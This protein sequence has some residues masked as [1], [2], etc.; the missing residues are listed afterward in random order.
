MTFAFYLQVQQ[1]GTVEVVRIDSLQSCW[2][3]EILHYNIE[4][5][6]CFV[7]L[8][9]K[10][11]AVGKTLSTKHKAAVEQALDSLLSRS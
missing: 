1:Q 10:G 11:Q 9:E 8:N 7:L 6:P 3:P 2:G 4:T 5:I